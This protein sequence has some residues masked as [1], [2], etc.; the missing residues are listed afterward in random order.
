MEKAEPERTAPVPAASSVLGDVLF[1]GRLPGA[2]IY[3]ASAGWNRSGIEPVL[4]KLS[5]FRT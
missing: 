3:E 4:G 2:V 1:R 5:V